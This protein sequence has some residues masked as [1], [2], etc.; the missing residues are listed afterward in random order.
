MLYCRHALSFDAKPGNG[1]T[2]RVETG[3][4]D[5]IGQATENTAGSTDPRAE[6]ESIDTL[7]GA[8]DAAT[9]EAGG[10]NVGRGIEVE[11][12]EPSDP[13]EGSFDDI[14]AIQER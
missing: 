9:D 1:S 5:S 14:A 13:H 8:S 6:T 12:D 3:E 11:N 7:S 4:E 2:S 10:G